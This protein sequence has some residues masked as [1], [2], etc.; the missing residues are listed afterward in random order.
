MIWVKVLFISA[1]SVYV[2]H[3]HVQVFMYSK[4]ENKKCI[5]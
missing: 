5:S 3:T 2:I 1:R 4:K